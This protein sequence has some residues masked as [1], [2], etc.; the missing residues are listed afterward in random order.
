MCALVGEDKLGESKTIDKDVNYFNFGL[1][2]EMYYVKDEINEEGTAYCFNGKES[3]KIADDVYYVY[4]LKEMNDEEQSGIVLVWTDYDGESATLS[5]F[6][7]KE[8]IKLDDDVYYYSAVFK[9]ENMGLFYLKDYSYDREEG[10][11][12][13]WDMKNNS[14]KIDDDVSEIV[15]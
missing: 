13:R 3:V 6:N 4:A 8:L 12:R 10:E 7:G 5:V 1:D 14:E 15:V 2:G 11:L 9:G